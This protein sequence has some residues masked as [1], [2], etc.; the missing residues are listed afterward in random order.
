MAL[1]LLPPALR[2]SHCQMPLSR[3]LLLWLLLLL[4]APRGAAARDS[5]ALR[6]EEYTV[7]DERPVNHML[8]HMRSTRFGTLH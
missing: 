8:A 1:L 2:Q 6:R 7:Q 3:L 4:V 5:E